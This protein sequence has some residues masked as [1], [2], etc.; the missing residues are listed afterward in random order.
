MVEHAKT[1]IAL[2]NDIN[3]G[4]AAA[5]TARARVLKAKSEL[6]TA[7]AELAR[8]EKTLGALTARLAKL[9]PSAPAATEGT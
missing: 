6:G 4:L 7:E 3:E 9:L 1:R 8:H 2:V 5:E